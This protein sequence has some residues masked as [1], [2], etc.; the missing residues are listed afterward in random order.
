MHRPSLHTPTL[1]LGKP[2]ARV[3]GVQSPGASHWCVSLPH[4]PSLIANAAVPQPWL[5]T[6]P[7]A[8]SLCPTRTCRWSSI[9]AASS[10]RAHSAVVLVSP[11]RRLASVTKSVR[12][13]SVSSSVTCPR[14]SRRSAPT[15]PLSRSRR[16]G[17]VLRSTPRWVEQ[18]RS[19][20]GVVQAVAS[21]DA[22]R[23]N[24]HVL[25]Y[26]ARAHALLGFRVGPGWVS[27]ASPG[28]QPPG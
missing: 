24:K 26:R 10:A 18:W 16:T 19:S 1:P 13:R 14:A 2:I 6:P 5:H 17:V 4:P 20:R 8:L 28:V 23:C 15:H 25:A 22:A 9:C 3:D 11:L 12:L 7:K 27:H 21:Q